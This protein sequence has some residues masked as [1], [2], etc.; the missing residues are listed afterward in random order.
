MDIFWKILR[1]N[2]TRHLLWQRQQ[3]RNSKDD[4][5]DEGGGKEVEEETKV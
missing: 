1:W 5:D 4:D 2:K 3:L